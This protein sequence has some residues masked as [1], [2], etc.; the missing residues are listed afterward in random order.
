MPVGGYEFLDPKTCED[1]DWS[2][3][4]DDGAIG[5]ILEVDLRY[6]EH[7]HD[8]HA[9]LPLAPHRMTV[10][11][12][13]LSGFAKLCLSELKGQISTVVKNW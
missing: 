8:L 1:W 10:T 6:P 2:M 12:K 5:Y 3:F 9:S 11:E 7:L 13:D 4:Q